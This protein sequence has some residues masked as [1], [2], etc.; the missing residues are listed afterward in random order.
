MNTLKLELWQN[1]AWQ[2]ISKYL[3]FPI[4]WAD[5]L[6][7]QLDE[8]ETFIKHLP[9]EFIQPLTLVKLTITNTPSARFPADYVAVLQARAETN[10]S[11]ITYNATTGK[12]TEIYERF[13]IVA[14]DN[15]IEL[16][17][18]KT[19]DGLKTYNHELYGI[20]LTKIMS[21]FIGDPITFTNALGNDY[22]GENEEIA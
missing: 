10:V 15:S 14:S 17:G 12:I 8:T 4:K 22:V 6:D 19:K 1:N 7:E 3:V 13:Y 5:L 18:I 20:E 11:S 16:V 9:K 21:G 2:D